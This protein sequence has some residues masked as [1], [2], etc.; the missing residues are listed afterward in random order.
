[1]SGNTVKHVIGYATVL[2]IAVV[3]T[4]QALPGTN[5]VTSDDIVNKQ[6]RKADLA[7]DAVRSKT[8]KN[9]AVRPADLAEAYYTE[10]EVYTKA[11]VNA[12]LADAVKKT[13]LTSYVKRSEL[14][15]RGVLRWGRIVDLGATVAVYEDNIPSGSPGLTVERTATGV[16]EVTVPGVVADGGRH[17]LFVSPEQ[18]QTTVFRACKVFQTTT[19][20][21][22]ADTLVVR[23]RCYDASATLSNS[24][25]HILVLQ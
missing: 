14:G 22:A 1:M 2:L 17:G 7:I 8:I 9:G 23:V 12:L 15:Q 20:G 10:S 16:Y 3:G 4:A 25:F 24:D 18:G 11:E 6:V 21:D 5:T 19:V 13:E